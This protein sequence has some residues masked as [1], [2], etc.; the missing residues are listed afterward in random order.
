MSATQNFLTVVTGTFNQMTVDIA[1]GFN[2]QIQARIPYSLENTSAALT[3]GLSFPAARRAYFQGFMQ[4]AGAAA[5]AAPVLTAIQAVGDLA[6][7]TS[8]TAATRTLVVDGYLLCSG[9]GK[10]VFY[11]KSEAANLTAKVLDGGSII[12]WNIGAITV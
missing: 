8:G 11:G 10:L 5:L 12:C 3:I 7:W 2:Y 6:V 4:P 1:S 9:S